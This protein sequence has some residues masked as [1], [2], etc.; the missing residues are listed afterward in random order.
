MTNKPT[1]GN[2]KLPLGENILD[3]PEVL[4]NSVQSRSLG[5]SS[6]LAMYGTDF[7]GRSGFDYLLL[8]YNDG[9]LPLSRWWSVARDRELR[10]YV[11]KSTA[12]AG[13][14]YGRVTAIKNLDWKIVA[15]DKADES[16]LDDYYEMFEQSHFGEGLR[17]LV[18]LYTTDNYTQDNGSFIELIGKGVETRHVDSFGNQF[19][20]KGELKKENIE[21]FAS[22]DASWAFRTY[23]REWP[24]VYTNPWSGQIHILHW[25]RVIARSQ[26]PQSYELGRGVGL[27]ATSRAFQALEIMQASNE[28]IYEKMTGQSPEIAIVQ[29]VAIRAIEAAVSDGAIQADNKG[30]VRFKGIVFVPS[31]MNPNAEAKIEKVGIKST[32]DGWDREKEMTLA[33]YLIAMAYATDARDLGWPATQ[34]GATKADAEIQDLKTSGRGRSD[35][36]RDLEEVLTNRILPKGLRFEFDVKDDLEDKRKAE[37]AKIRAET[38]AIN[39]QSGVLDANEAREMAAR[40][41]DIM[42]EFLETRTIIQ[43]GD[44]PSK[45][46][47]NPV[48]NETPVDEDMDTEADPAIADVY[49]KSLEGSKAYNNDIRIPFHDSM[50]QILLNY[51]NP[52]SAAVQVQ[53]VFNASA[54][55]A[56]LQGIRDGGANGIVSASQLDTDEL[57]ELNSWLSFNDNRALDLAF[58]LF[59][60]TLEEKQNRVNLWANKGLDTSYNM[61]L[62]S[63]RSNPALEWH[64]SDKVKEHCSDCLKYNGKVYRAKV[65]KR[66]A[67]A[68]RS[69]NLECKG[70]QC[71]CEL[72]KT[73]KP[74]TRGRP[75]APSGA[76]G[77]SFLQK[78]SSI[79]RWYKHKGHNHG[80]IN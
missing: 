80:R 39:I 47:A 28:Y 43:G 36:I 55:Q 35:T 60:A 51:D 13:I 58:D 53:D 77:K 2:G 57:N 66:Y 19:T 73:E 64:Y 74:I 69:D 22:I 21:T 50:M 15:D 9:H 72:L 75:S 68:P 54:T 29:N 3:N 31:D 41:G 40:E 16:K 5:E 12:L 37:I 42:P 45:G 63:G 26:F 56:Y 52:Y 49:E 67:I 17:T 62:M 44:N 71:E 79:Y 24:V 6:P 1:N 8:G 18:G 70:F 10:A 61:G 30:L 7:F 23:N 46:T 38:L 59:D 25:T 34:T 33:L 20:A 11:R 48:D 32:P 78:H 27:C 14:T 65:W 76:R 4:E